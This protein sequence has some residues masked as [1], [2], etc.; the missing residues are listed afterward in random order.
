MKAAQFSPPVAV[1]VALW[2]ISHRPGM[3]QRELAHAM[4]GANGRQSDAHQQ[5]DLLETK[6]LVERRR[7]TR[8]LRLYPRTQ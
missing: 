2:I 7:D 5:V 4:W 1:D 3:T 6:G 8:P